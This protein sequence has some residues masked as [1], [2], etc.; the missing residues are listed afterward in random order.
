MSKKTSPED[1]ARKDEL[2]ELEEEMFRRL[3]QRL[4][5]SPRAPVRGPLAWAFELVRTIAIF[6][7]TLS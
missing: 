3:D 7:N 2:D 6:I 1:K 4:N 5:G